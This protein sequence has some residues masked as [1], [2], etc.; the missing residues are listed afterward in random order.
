MYQTKKMNIRFALYLSAFLFLLLQYQEV[1]GRESIAEVG[2]AKVNITPPV[3]YAHYRGI[4]TGVSDSLYTKAVV[5]KSVQGAF[6]IVICDLLWIERDLSVKVRRLIHK[7]TGIPFDNV[8]LSATHTHTSPAYHFNILELNASNRPSNYSDPLIMGMP[9]QEWLPTQI[10]SSV[11]QA[12]DN[13]QQVLLETNTFQVSGLSYNRRFILLDGT[14]QMNPGM[15]NMDINRVAGTV[16]STYSVILIRRAVDG[17]PLGCIANYGLHTDTFGSDKWSADFPGYLDKYLTERFGSEFIS[18]FANGPC[19]DINHLD[20]L[21]KKKPMA[22]AEIGNRLATEIVGNLGGFSREKIE[23]KAISSYVFAPLQDFT[24]KEL[25]W[26]TAHPLD[27]IYSERSFYTFRRSSKIRSLQRMRETAEAI[28]PSVSGASWTLPLLVQVLKISDN[29]AIV[30]LPGEL[31]SE[32]GKTVR[33][34]SPFEN[35]IIIE[36]THC[37]IGYVPTLEAFS[38]GGYEA[39]N[40]RLAPG[41][42]ELLSQRAIDLLR[43]TT[44][45]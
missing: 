6:A 3:G 12:F 42:G 23:L 17:K 40:S 43:K 28:P 35:T 4:S 11:I 33:E 26:A 9:Y 22:S 45:D 27:S 5:F 39:I 37:H 13:A 44:N 20:F 15:D 1:L 2:I 38:Q 34:A 10:A 16:D 14:V 41:S 24:E 29:T 36:L 18:V 8:I 32:F 31:F 7:Q 21:T 19:G 25:A 30:G